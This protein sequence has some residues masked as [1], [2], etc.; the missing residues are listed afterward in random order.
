MGRPEVRP[1]HLTA[2]GARRVRVTLRH[3]DEVPKSVPRV[4]PDRMRLTDYTSAQ[5]DGDPGLLAVVREAIARKAVHC[6]LRGGENDREGPAGSSQPGWIATERGTAR[7]PGKERRRWRFPRLMSPATLGSSSS[8]TTTTTN[9]VGR[10]LVFGTPTTRASTAVISRTATV[11]S[12]SSRSTG[13]PG[14]AR[15]RAAIW[16]GMG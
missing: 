13:R 11:S 9:D 1:S 15:S 5:S 16:D 4:H 6:R 8:R 14:P 3:P 7:T 2:D 10:R 12:S